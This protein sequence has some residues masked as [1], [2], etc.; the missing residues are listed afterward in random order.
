MELENKNHNLEEQIKD[1]KRQEL[2]LAFSTVSRLKPFKLS[3]FFFFNFFLSLF[4]Y[5]L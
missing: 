4:S 1:T 3:L 5:S 2:I